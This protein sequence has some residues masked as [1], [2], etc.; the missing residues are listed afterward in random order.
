MTLDD[1][2][3]A[4]K[5]TVGVKQT[6][7]AVTKELA[8]KVFVAKDADERVTEKLKELCEEKAV[9]LVQVETMHELGKACGIH[10][11]AAAAAILKS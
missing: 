3:Q 10:V 9:S 1:L 7:K 11:K 5:R 2:M 6:E 8:A 4:E